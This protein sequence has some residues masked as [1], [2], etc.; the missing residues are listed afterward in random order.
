MCRRD[1]EELS[2][3]EP[4]FKAMIR[5][6]DKA[7]KESGAE[8]KMPSEVYGWYLVNN[9]MRM[10]PSDVANI[11]GRSESYKHTD[12]LAALHRMWSGGGLAAKDSETKKKKKESNGHAMV[13]EDEDMEEEVFLANEDD[14]RAFIDDPED[15][16]VLANFR[17]ARQALGQARTSRGFYPVKDPNL[18]RGSGFATSKGRG[19]G[20]G[21]NRD[22]QQYR[23]LPGCL[24][25]GSCFSLGSRRSC[26]RL[27]RRRLIITTHHKPTYHITT[28][29]HNSS[30]LITPYHIPSHHSSTSHTSPITAPLL[31]TTHHN[32]TSERSTSHHN[33]SQLITSQLITAPL[34]TPLLTPHLS[35]PNSSQL[36]FSH[37]SS[38]V[39]F[40][41]LSS[42]TS[43]NF[44]LTLDT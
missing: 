35:H 43:P 7:L 40:S 21:F 24:S 18:N 38:Q 8:G 2:D 1:F 44:T 28:S 6:L 14:E 12:I 29:H 30:Q 33:S 25:R 37:L 34:L 5:R 26:S 10:E 19:K 9:Y 32:S 42:H 3:C 4:R 31:I 22:N 41:H 16:E 20:R 23:E 13:M 17:D 36:H 11:R 15:D 39:H 27:R